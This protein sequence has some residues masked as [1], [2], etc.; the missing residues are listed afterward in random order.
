[1]CECVNFIL[2]ILIIK[3]MNTELQLRI[4]SEKVIFIDV[5]ANRRKTKH[6]RA[7]L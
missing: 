5:K 2:I 1:M 7:C 3:K 6:L 4:S